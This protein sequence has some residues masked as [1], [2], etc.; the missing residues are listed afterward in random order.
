MRHLNTHEAHV[1]G[2]R[3]WDLQGHRE[4]RVHQQLEGWQLQMQ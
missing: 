3:G 2:P 4:R 1:F